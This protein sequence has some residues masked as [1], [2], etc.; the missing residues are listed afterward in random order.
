[1]N[2]KDIVGGVERA[3]YNQLASLSQLGI[4]AKLFSQSTENDALP[5][6][7]EYFKGGLLK[8]VRNAFKYIYRRESQVKLRNE[9]KSFSPDIIHIHSFEGGLTNSI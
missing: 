5:D 9:I 4:E 7:L 2:N 1:M 6:P 8:K 3:A